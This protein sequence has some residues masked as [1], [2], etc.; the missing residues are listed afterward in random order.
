MTL[1]F[2]WLITVVLVGQI[3]A[4][5]GAPYAQRLLRAK[6]IDSSWF[7]VEGAT[8]S[9]IK[10]S[11]LKIGPK[12]PYGLSRDAVTL[13]RI[14]W[15][16]PKAESRYPGEYK[17]KA[18][19]EVSVA[20][21]TLRDSGDLDV[22]EQREW[23]RYYSALIKHEYG[24]ARKAMQTKKDIER[25]LLEVSALQDEKRKHEAAKKLIVANRN[26]DIWYDA[27]TD[28]GRKQ[29]VLLQT[30]AASRSYR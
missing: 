26:W 27:S 12:D 1:R 25:K 21:P 4:Y 6:E 10:E 22:N 23:N 19:V 11:I 13:W 30:D 16:L 7:E 24:H 20:L 18:S 3:L 29:G 14:K 5:E 28:H 15:D 2:C 9:G 8:L 17:P